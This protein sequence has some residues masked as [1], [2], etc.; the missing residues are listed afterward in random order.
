[1]GQD[2]FLGR[3]RDAR[4]A[5]GGTEDEE[6]QWKVMEE[7]HRQLRAASKIVSVLKAKVQALTEEKAQLEARE[8]A[9][10][11]RLDALLAS[12]A[13]WRAKVRPPPAV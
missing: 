2:L 7:L 11:S 3:P 6:A 5:P 13:A 1:M 8:A 12:E 4:D 9:A 10:A